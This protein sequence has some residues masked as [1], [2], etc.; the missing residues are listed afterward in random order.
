MATYR[1]PAK[2]ADAGTVISHAASMVVRWRRRD[3]VLWDN[4][5]TLHKATDFDFAHERRVIRRTTILEQ[6]PL[7]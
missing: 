7:L 5:S 3:L 4:R 2:S 6:G 1:R